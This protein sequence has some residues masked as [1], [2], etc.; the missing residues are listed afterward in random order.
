MH[1]VK[2]GLLVYVVGLVSCQS[3]HYQRGRCGVRSHR[4]TYPDL[5]LFRS[6]GNRGGRQICGLDLAWRR[7][8]DRRPFKLARCSVELR[9]EAWSSN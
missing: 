5:L 6:A 2:I 4:S 7:R 1:G 9:R 3:S 8:R